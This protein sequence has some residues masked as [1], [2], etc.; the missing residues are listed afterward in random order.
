MRFP[1]GKREGGKVNQTTDGIGIIGTGAYLPRRRL[2]NSEVATLTGC[3]PG[4]IVE[5]TGIHSRRVADHAE[6]TSDLAV[7]AA[8]RALR[9]A[10][11]SADRI[12]LIILAT[13]TPDWP[14][15]A[16]SCRL[17]ALLGCRKIPAFDLNA[18]CTGFVYALVAAASLLRDSGFRFA[19]VI[20]ADTYSRILDVHDR[21]TGV[22]FGD[23]AGAAIVGRVPLGYGIFATD[24]MADGTKTELVQVPAG[25]SRRPASVDTVKAGG[26]YFKMDGRGVKR[27][28][29]EEV[30]QAIHRVLESAALKVDQVDLIITHQANGVLLDDCL[31]AAGVDLAKIHRTIDRYGNTAA[32][33]IPITIDDAVRAGR[34]RDGD[35]LLLVGF[36]GGMTLGSVVLR[37]YRQ[38]ARVAGDTEERALTDIPLVLGE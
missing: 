8:R 4:W 33:S 13:S 12:D 25:G 31:T 24:L 7:V 35:R 14:L 28:V 37:W 27:F 19:L 21:A 10:D 22:L 6:A 34:L 30:P 11:L 2:D 32:A 23:G 18:V 26:H 38:G 1:D 36:G 17:Q 3:D 9:R 16:T 29:K 20:G 15:P 5:R